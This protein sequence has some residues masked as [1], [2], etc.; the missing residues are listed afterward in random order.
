MPHLELT[1]KTDISSFRKLAMAHHPDRNAGDPTAE[2]KFKELNEAYSILSDPQKR[3]AYDRYGKAA[4][5]NGMGGGHG[6]DFSQFSDI[7]DNIFGEFMG[8]GRGQGRS[9]ALRG[10]DLRYDL[11]LTLEESFAGKS[12]TIDIETMARCEPCARLILDANGAVLRPRRGVNEHDRQAGAAHGFDLRVAGLEAHGDDAVDG[13]PPHGAL[14]RA[15]ERRDE[16]D[17]EAALLGDDRDTLGESRKE[18]VAED[19]PE[20][21]RGQHADRGR[22]ARAEHPRDGVR[23]VAQLFGD[24]PDA[25]RCLH[26]ETFRLVERK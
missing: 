18:G 17:P 10:A 20:R 7:F 2:A 8:R 23:P 11:E 19:L 12:A 1:P 16:Q 26:A 22:L 4:F 25:R 3:A 13:R 6:A 9:S 14:E 5:Q 24:R 21:L 15:A